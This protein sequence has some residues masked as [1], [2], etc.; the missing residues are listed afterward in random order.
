[1]E[2]TLPCTS[3]DPTWP[4]WAS[5][6]LETK[7]NNKKAKRKYEKH[8]ENIMYLQMT[9]LLLTT[10]LAGAGSAAKP[11]SF[12][13]AIQTVE[14]TD[15]TGFPTGTSSAVGMGNAT[16]LG[17]FTAT[18][19]VEIDFTINVAIG[20]GVFTAANGDSLF[21]DIIGRRPSDR[22]P[23]CHLYR[24]RA[25]HHRRYGSVRGGHGELHQNELV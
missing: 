2:G 25:G 6:D 1:M 10:A 24:G 8:H 16:H 13:G 20:S 23:G 18:W 19:F 12:K 21:T 9:A 5:S 3:A 15:V 11:R 7:N 17:S 22:E 4:R 14:I